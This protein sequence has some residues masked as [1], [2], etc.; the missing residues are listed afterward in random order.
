M[1]SGYC[2]CVQ[3]SSCHRDRCTLHV[4]LFKSRAFW[5]SLTFTK[6]IFFPNTDRARRG[7]R[8]LSRVNNNSTLLSYPGRIVPS[9]GSHQLFAILT[10]TFHTFPVTHSRHYEAHF[11]MHEAPAR[12]RAKMFAAS[13]TF[14]RRYPFD[15]TDTYRGI[16]RLLKL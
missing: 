7:D 5:L 6:D 15:N 16:K 12:R 3:A 1:R 2:V 14:L 4:V 9:Q 13:N 8:V 11:L 10:S